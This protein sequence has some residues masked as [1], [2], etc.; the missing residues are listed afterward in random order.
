MNYDRES[1]IPLQCGQMA[2]LR[3]SRQGTE[4][5]L[6][7]GLDTVT[8]HLD[9]KNLANDALDKEDFP[10]KFEIGSKATGIG[11]EVDDLKFN[12]LKLGDSEVDI[13]GE[14]IHVCVPVDEMD[15][16]V[17][18]NFDIKGH[19]SSHKGAR[20]YVDPNSPDKPKVCFNGEIGLDG[21]LKELIHIENEVPTDIGAETKMAMLDMDIDNADE[22]ELLFT[23][24]SMYFMEDDMEL[25]IKFDWMSRKSWGDIYN[26]IGDITPEN[27]KKMMDMDLMRD[28]LK[29][30]K[31]S[32]PSRP[33]STKPEEGLVNYLG[34]VKLDLNLTENQTAQNP[35]ADYMDKVWKIW[36]EDAKTKENSAPTEE[37]SGFYG[38]WRKAADAVVGF[39]DKVVDSASTLTNG[40]KK[41]LAYDSEEL[42]RSRFL[43]YLQESFNKSVTGS[44]PVM[45]A[46]AKTAE[47][48]LIPLAKKKANEAIARLKNTA[49][50][51][52]ITRTSLKRPYINVQDLADRESLSRIEAR[53][54]FDDYKVISR[55]LREIRNYRDKDKILESTDN[56]LQNIDHYINSVST[57][58]SDRNA[59]RVLSEKI[60]PYLSNLRDNMYHQSGGYIPKDL[61]DKT[62]AMLH[63]ARAKS[64]IVAENIN[65]RNRSLELELTTRWFNDLSGGPEVTV[66][67]EELCAQGVGTLANSSK[68]SDREL[69]AYDLSG[70]I[71]IDAVN[72]MI[73]KLSKDGQF[74]FCLHNGEIST[75]SSVNGN[76]NNR[77][78]FEDP[79]QIKWNARNQKH[80]IKLRD[81][82]CETRLVNA[83]KKCGIKD[84]RSKI[85]IL[86]FILNTIG[87]GIG[88][89]CKFLSD[90]ADNVITGSVGQNLIDV[91]VEL[92]PKICG[93]SVCMQPKLKDTDIVTDIENVNPNL[94]SM[95]GKIVGIVTSP[96]TDVVKSEIVDDALMTFMESEVSQPLESP[97][98]IYPEKIVS[99]AGS[100]TVLS[101]IK[102]EDEL[103]EFFSQCLNKSPQCQ[104]DHFLNIDAKSSTRAPAT[105][106]SLY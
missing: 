38:L 42:I 73:A 2:R 59:Q 20:A 25:P 89:T 4:K 80:E 41:K 54:N 12:A 49:N 35:D 55:Q 3:M 104:V 66:A 97:I 74:D 53:M 96:I 63:R 92:E 77:C 50:F 58:S 14:K 82:Q 60:I 31:G 9:L 68:I 15:M 99:E 103:S 61:K 71:S 27:M 47:M 24:M 88:S 75:C 43:P 83:D 84:K 21:Q 87:S 23:Y 26:L 34:R 40:V 94:A 8:D 76:Y 44:A 106:G 16:S 51:S 90:Q 48:K 28:K 56:I 98:G 37:S 22:D 52:S 45:A 93:S 36:Q 67:T 79:P 1:C 86:G 102:P 64:A 57:S 100:I 65:Y 29:E 70:S 72:A 33:K 78:R 18:A 95:I 17:D 5:L 69:Q 105:Q 46:V 11:V 91:T 10:F 13:N 30:I 32:L 85:P 39:K 6:K 101:N 62:L 81:L 7:I 19:R